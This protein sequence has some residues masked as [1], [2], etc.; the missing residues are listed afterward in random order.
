PSDVPS[1]S[2]PHGPT[3]GILEATMATGP[4]RS[5]VTSTAKI[6][7]PFVSGGTVTQ[8]L[9]LAS[10]EPDPSNV[11]S[12]PPGWPFGPASKISMPTFGA[13]WPQTWVA[14]SSRT[15]VITGAAAVAVA[16]VDG[17]TVVVRV[18]VFV[19][20]FVGVLVGV[21]V[22]VFVGVLLGGFVL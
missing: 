2:A 22:P 1:R 18:A 13:P 21:R 5:W 11:S 7:S 8:K 4:V 20:V 10:V 17:V 19:A 14:P 9:P 6:R 16:V 3:V 15:G 12:P